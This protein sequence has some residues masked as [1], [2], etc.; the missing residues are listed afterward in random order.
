[1]TTQVIFITQIASVFAFI[2]A[3]FFLYRVLVSQKDATIELLKEE[4]TYLQAQIEVAKENTPDKLAQRLS[5]RIHIL[6]AELERLSKDHYKHSD[7]IRQKERELGDARDALSR[8]KEQ[9]DA[10]QEIASE[11][12]CPLCGARMVEHAYSDEDYHGHDISH[13]TISFECGYTVIDGREESP[14]KN[15]KA[16]N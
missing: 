4:N 15:R 1:M 2:V 14:C 3:L 12:M 10:A 13:E 7:D 8:L 6:S 16:N 11:F 5:D 9:L